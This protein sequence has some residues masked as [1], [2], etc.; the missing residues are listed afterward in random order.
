MSE[1]QRSGTGP[2]K[3][4]QVVV[5]DGVAYLAGQVAGAEGFSQP[6]REQVRL[7]FGRIDELLQ[8]VGSD[9]TKMLSV[10][11]LLRDITDFPVFSEEWDAWIDHDHL[12]SRAT[13]QAELVSPD[14][15][16]ELIVTAAL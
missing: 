13:M 1:I 5:H 3:F 12:P 15:L 4:S 2:Y 8:S 16:V 6:V 14:I 10:T 11:V 7:V 9:R